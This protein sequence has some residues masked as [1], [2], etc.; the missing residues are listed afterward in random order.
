MAKQI[1]ILA[2]SASKGSYWPARLL[3]KDGAGVWQ[4]S[5]F[6][7]ERW[8]TGVLTETRLLELYLVGSQVE[9]IDYVFPFSFDIPWA[10]YPRLSVEVEKMINDATYVSPVCN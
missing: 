6:E 3:Q 2:A 8:A 4:A 1:W 10:D 9:R 7:D 5:D